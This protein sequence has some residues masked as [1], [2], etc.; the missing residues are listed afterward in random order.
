MISIIILLR[1]LVVAAA[2][3]IKNNFFL[4]LLQASLCSFKKFTQPDL[5]LRQKLLNEEGA[6]ANQVDAFQAIPGP[7]GQPGPPGNSSGND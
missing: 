6:V 3:L 4:V 1:L 5:Q 2:K 7:V